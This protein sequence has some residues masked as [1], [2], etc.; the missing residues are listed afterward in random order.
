MDPIQRVERILYYYQLNIKYL[1]V[2][3]DSSDLPI[4]EIFNGLNKMLINKDKRRYQYYG[5]KAIFINDFTHVK[6]EKTI[7]G[8]LRCV[9]KDLLP[10]LINTDTDE[11]RDI[12]VDDKD[13]I[14]ETTHFVISYMKKKPVIV[15]E[16]N[17]FGA[18]VID[19]INYLQAIG[20]EL[21]LLE[22]IGFKPIV[23][24]ELKTFK[25]RIKRC[26]E[27]HVKIHKDNIPKIESADVKLFNSLILAEEQFQAEYATLIMKF[28]YTKNKVREPINTTIDHLIDF[29]SKDNKN[30]ELFNKLSVRAEDREKDDLIE[31]FDLLID[32]V[33]SDV[34]VQKRAK[35]RALI[36]NDMFSRMKAEM[37]KKKV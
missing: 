35:Y 15:I 32:K 21:G 30:A 18:R 1:D 5:E 27:F 9:R 17:Q 7:Q 23:K 33:R 4:M 29:I 16:F 10:E 26:S 2:I 37:I 8:K 34:K 12:E 31:V 11:T 36:S 14:V 20:I 13:G 25:S 3:I 19:F 22:Y 6:S 24:D 28:D